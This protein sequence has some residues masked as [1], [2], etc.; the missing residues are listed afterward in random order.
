MTPTHPNPATRDQTISDRPRPTEVDV[1]AALDRHRAWV[2]SGGREG[3]RANLSELDL[4]GMDL[5]GAMLASARLNGTNLNGAK[6]NGA[7]LN[8]AYFI[9]ATLARTELNL[10]NLAG[11]RLS[12]AN[13]TAAEF[14]RADLSGAYLER[15]RLAGANL[16][17]ASLAHA[18][19]TRADL[20]GANLYRA[21]LAQAVITRAT[22]VG[23]DLHRA[24][25]RRADLDLAD[26]SGANLRASDLTEAK[27]HRAKL[28]RAD[29]RQADLTGALLLGADLSRA[30][31]KGA[32]LANAD[33]RGAR[34]HKLD[35]AFV[36]G[37]QFSALAS[38][39]RAL[40]C[41]M[42]LAP[43]CGW[44]DRRGWSW[45]SGQLAFTS[46]PNDPWSILR[47]SYAGPRVLFLFFTVIV[48]ALPYVARAAVYSAAAPV[49]RQLAEETAHRK[50]QVEH[51]LAS[52]PGNQD[53][54][55]E[56]NRLEEYEA[57]VR[58]DRQPVWKVALKW[59]QGRIWPTALA[60]L[61]MFYNV[62]LYVLI[63]QVSALRDEEERSGWTPA[64]KDYRH[65]V[66][67]HRLVVILFYVSVASF[68][69]N[70]AQMLGEEV[71][72]PRLK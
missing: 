26:L 34:V 21:D 48:F 42:I 5:S 11:A 59:D 30:L 57:R 47:Q 45:A 29:L 19:L 27:L 24:S 37:A 50:K 16:S 18:D 25:L 41:E 44:L 72:V 52:R 20:A 49:E 60:G 69:F 40:T 36:R 7:D 17:Y 31:L 1:R 13:L 62:G 66:W 71:L 35:Q 12:E 51:R 67:V 38:R 56:L 28:P 65:L 55:D 53:L 54:L 58:F 10:A 14:C 33:L 2:E 64:W 22:L 68:L 63:T 61:L 6:L 70:I 32:R 8:G 46:D 39:W 3:A 4:S 23:A 43:L 15:A 9:G